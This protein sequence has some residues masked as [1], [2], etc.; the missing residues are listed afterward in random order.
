[1]ASQKFPI[2]VRVDRVV[3]VPEFLTRHEAADFVAFYQDQ[4]AIK[5][6]SRL[7]I[8]PVKWDQAGKPMFGPQREKDSFRVVEAPAVG[9]GDTT[10]AYHGCPEG[11]RYYRPAWWGKPVRVAGAACA[12][13]SSWFERQPAGVRVAALVLAAALL[14]TVSRAGETFLRVLRSLHDLIK[15]IQGFAG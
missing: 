1:M 11:C 5:K 8:A 6:C 9:L 13:V 14:M 2:P 3:R 15:A 10:L 12:A 7:R 4:G